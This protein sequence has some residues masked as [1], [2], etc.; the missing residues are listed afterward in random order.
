MSWIDFRHARYD[1][2]S[3]NYGMYELGDCLEKYGEVA[4]SI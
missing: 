1:P 4:D 3:L 2:T